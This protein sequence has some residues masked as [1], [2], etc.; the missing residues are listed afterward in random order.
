MVYSLTLL[1]L[2]QPVPVVT[3]NPEL[4]QQFAKVTALRIEEL[5]ELTAAAQVRKLQHQLEV[6]ELKAK[7]AQVQAPKTARVEATSDPLAHLQ[8]LGVVGIN[9]SV[10]VLQ[11]VKILYPTQREKEVLGLMAE[12]KLNKEIAE[13][14]N[15]SIETVKT[16]RKNVKRKLGLKSQLDYI[17]YYKKMI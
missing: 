5:A 14:L 16:H 2:S 6:A 3:E 12:G 13:L 8:V 4:Q 10:Q 11:K 1:L 17:K 9:A 15:I 7:I